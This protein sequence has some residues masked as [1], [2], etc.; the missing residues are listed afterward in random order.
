MLPTYHGRDSRV[1]VPGGR[2][3]NMT[4]RRE[5]RRHE[6]YYMQLP[7]TFTFANGATCHGVSQDVSLVGFFVNVQSELNLEHD[8]R[9]QGTLQLGAQ[10]YTFQC[11]L[12]RRTS[13]GIGISIVKDSAILGYAITTH[14]FNEI[15]SCH[16]R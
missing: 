14:I 12:T 4:A 3:E 8:L 6:R 9:G 2:E 10:R 5:K 16:L 15:S 1:A 11:R 7:V 13:A